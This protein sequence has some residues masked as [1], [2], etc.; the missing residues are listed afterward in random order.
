MPKKQ[1]EDS[2][3]GEKLIR[4]FAAL[5]F[6]GQ[7]KSMTDLARMLGCSKPTVRRIV[8]DISFAYSVQIMEETVGKQ[9]VFWIDKPAKVPVLSLSI[10]ELAVLEMCSAFTRHLLGKSQF[11]EAARGL[12]KS[13]GLLPPNTAGTSGKEFACFSPGSI[14]YTP[15]QEVLR[16]LIEAITKKKVCNIT[17]QALGAE[18]S[19][20]H[21]IM[22]LKIFSHK[23]TVYVHARRCTPTGQPFTDDDFYPLLAVHRFKKVI[24]LENTYEFPAN[25]DFE[26]FFNQTFGVIKGEGFRVKARFTGWAAK[27]VAERIWSANQKITPE[28]DGAIILEFDAT[29]ESEVIGWVL[30]FGAEAVLL[31]TDS[32]RQKLVDEIMGMLDAYK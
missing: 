11:E 13:Q 25:Y 23:D 2:T 10:D 31:S 15:H 27:H 28:E 21:H 4:T 32:L 8:N 7:R 30:S 5:L 20:A 14:D 16:N 12:Q 3:Y 17:Y 29:S 9:L 26:G 18:Q 24:V 22:P 1:N 6:T 19:R